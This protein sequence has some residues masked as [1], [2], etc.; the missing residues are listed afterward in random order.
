MIS[1]VNIYVVGILWIL[2]N[3]LMFMCGGQNLWFCKASFR[4]CYV[5]SGWQVPGKSW[6]EKLHVKFWKNTNFPTESW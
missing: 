4:I 3:V 1:Q 5:S 6:K 2:R